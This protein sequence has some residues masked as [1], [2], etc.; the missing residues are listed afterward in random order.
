MYSHVLQKAL[1]KKHIKLYT[2]V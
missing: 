2:Q 1:L